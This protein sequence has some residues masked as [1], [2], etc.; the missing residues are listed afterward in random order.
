M[1]KLWENSMQTLKKFK[2]DFGIF[3]S[4]LEKLLK[5]FEEI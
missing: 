4:E 3:L 2:G 1:Q 5:N